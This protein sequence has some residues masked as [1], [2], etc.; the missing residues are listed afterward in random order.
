MSIEK[1]IE[2]VS[3]ALER[4]SELV[5]TAQRADA[6]TNED[7]TEEASGYLQEY[8]EYVQ[9]AA[10]AR[11]DTSEEYGPDDVDALL[12]DAGTSRDEAVELLNEWIEEYNDVV[13]TMKQIV[14]ELKTIKPVA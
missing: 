12:E 13:E 1:R 14:S 3:A 7:P 9:E 8:D 11:D 2:K 6:L 4:L 10:A 5:E